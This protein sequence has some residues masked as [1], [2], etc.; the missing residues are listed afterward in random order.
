MAGKLPHVPP[1]SQCSRAAWPILPTRPTEQFMRC[2][3]GR[4][5]T[6]PLD[7]LT[8]SPYVT[9]AQLLRVGNREAG[10]LPLLHHVQVTWGHVQASSSPLGPGW[11]DSE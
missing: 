10:G 9:Y 11:G 7:L 3:G 5:K 4:C 8:W 2:S 6:D 1:I